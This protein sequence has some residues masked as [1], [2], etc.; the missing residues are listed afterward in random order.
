MAGSVGLGTCVGVALGSGVVVAGTGLG[1]EVSAGAGVVETISGVGDASRGV[2]T[3]GV[4]G[5]PQPDSHKI[6][7]KMH[8]DRGEGFV[9]HGLL[10][11]VILRQLFLHPAG[12][13]I[14]SCGANQIFQARAHP[15]WSPSKK[16]TDREALA[17]RP[18]LKNTFR[19]FQ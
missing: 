3:T 4:D 1:V 8:R 17:S 5:V 13:V 7:T 14:G 9:M 15:G 16:S 6:A 12:Q 11:G 19:I 10:K 2:L 18:A